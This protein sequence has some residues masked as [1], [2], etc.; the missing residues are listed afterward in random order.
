MYIPSIN[1]IPP[2]ISHKYDA[3]QIDEAAIEDGA[4]EYQH[5]DIGLE[6]RKDDDDGDG[7]GVLVSLV[8]Q[9]FFIV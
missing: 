4:D 9:C 5:H 8:L 2:P 6:L 1:T 3:Y 7:Y